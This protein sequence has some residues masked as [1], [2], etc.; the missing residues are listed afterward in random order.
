MG[1]FACCRC[2]ERWKV[3]FLTARRYVS[4]G[5]SSRHVFICLSVTRRY[6]TKA[7]K[8]R[9]T[10]TT[11]RDS[12]GTLVLWR[13]Q[14]L[15]GDAPFS[16]KFAIIV[17]YPPF[18]HNDFDQYPLIVPQPR[19][20][21]KNVQLALIGSWPRAFQRAIDEPCT[22][23]LTRQK[24]GTQRYFAVFARKIQSKE[25]CYKV[26]LRENFQM[27]SC[28]YII[29]PSNGP[30]MDCGRRSHYLTF[31]LKVT[32]TLRKRRFHSFMLLIL[33]CLSFLRCR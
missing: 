9:I 6:C 13:Q 30:Y 11:Q 15:V 10:Q 20:L 19:E 4:A 33:R 14:S 17:T 2:W 23:P 22:L 12:T 24:G 8:H 16:L 31:A 29:P 28:S 27:Q 3:A 7:P 21:S 32:H 18:K 5:I 1:D 26:S 25:V